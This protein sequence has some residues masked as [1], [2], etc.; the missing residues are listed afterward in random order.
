M[1]MKRND[2]VRSVQ[3]KIHDDDICEPDKDF[4]IELYDPNDEKKPR[5]PGDDTTTTV[6]IIDEDNPGILGFAERE[7]KVKKKDGDTFEIKITRADGCDGEISCMYKVE[8]VAN[9]THAAQEFH[10]YVP[11]FYPVQF[12]H[13]QSEQII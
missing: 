13:Q 9:S 1:I 4:Y 3:V 5:L 8:G 6:T 10:D 12:K 7:I 2:K 11:D